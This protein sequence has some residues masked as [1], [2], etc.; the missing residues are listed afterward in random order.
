MAHIQSLDIKNFR[1]F[2]HLKVS[3]EAS[4]VLIKGENGTG[5]TALL[6]AIYYLCYLRSFKSYA[7]RDL[8]RFNQDGFFIHGSF[9]LDENGP[10]IVYLQIGV[11]TQK[12]LIKLNNKPAK[13]FKDLFNCLRVV[14]LAENDLQIV[15]GGPD[16]RRS[17]IDN[18]VFLQESNFSQKMHLYRSA[19][20]Q[21]NALLQ[22]KP[23]D[24]DLYKILT[25]KLWTIACEIQKLRLHHLQEIEQE[26][27]L[28]QAENLLN[29]EIDLSYYCRYSLQRSFDEFYH[30]NFGLQ[31]EETR[32]QRTLFG[33]HLDDLII[34]WH[35]TN[36]RIY[37]SRGQQKLIVLL[38]KIAQIKGLIKK[39]GL[40][41]LLLDDFITDFDEE[42][43][44]QL[45]PLLFSLKCFLLFTC[46]QKK[47]FLEN[48]LNKYGV[49]MI[50]LEKN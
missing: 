30:L 10:E 16:S 4:A 28:V 25:K 24:D 12:K 42:R 48:E 8:I 2:D 41:I 44:K 29:C 5:K 9:E 21:R 1:C 11:T 27:K 39:G 35:K 36:A 46:A 20:N 33:I 43:I 50:L 37:A 22:Q 26:L 13:T 32:M 23:F 18:Y 15:Q 47:S 38:L 40:C 34:K 7:P 19:L 3:F 49:Q 17:F 6:E 45:L 31:S 14:S